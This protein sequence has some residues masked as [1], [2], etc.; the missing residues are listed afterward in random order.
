MSEILIFGGTTEGR[1]ISQVL[2]CNNIKCD[3]CVATEYGEQV[4]KESEN[5]NVH[6]GRMSLS[7]MQEFYRS[8]KTKIII[9]ATHPYATVVSENIRQSLIDDIK[10]IRFERETKTSDNDF[11]QYFDSVEDCIKELKNIKGNIFLTTGSKDLSKFCQ[12]QE[13]KNRII[14]RVLPGMESLKLCYDAGLEGK[15]IIAMQGPFSKAMNLLQIKEY[16]IST[17]VTKQS[18]KNGG[19]DEK[20]LACKKAGINCFVIKKE[21]ALNTKGIIQNFNDLFIELEK[22]LH[23][24]INHSC[25]LKINLCGIGM[26][27][28]DCLTIEVKKKI[29]ESKYIFGAQRMIDSVESGGKKYPYYLSKDIIPIL[30]DI[31]KNNYG[32]ITVSVLFSGDS[33][34]FSGSK[35]LSQELQKIQNVEI[36]S[37]PGISSLSYTAARFNI[38]YEDAKILSMHGINEEVWAPLL[39]E[40]LREGEKIFF[41]TSGKEDVMRIAEYLSE[42][43]KQGIKYVILLG[44][45]LSY[46]KERL[47]KIKSS[48][49]NKITEDGL[50]SGFLVKTEENKL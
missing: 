33:G 24:K 5:V 35:K 39:K 20:L 1:I 6:V 29:E 38:N 16:G 25:N 44:Y 11:C 41:I 46:K 42:Y 43:E 21:S 48:E 30:Q 26:G 13:I 34:F 14:A 40:Y 8:K 23:K 32:E 22:L 19:W 50:Y 45:E 37:Y 49:I 10:L 36:S 9:D 18:G 15:Q 31:Q 7:E 28:P 17:L 3:L 27:N 47:Y 4:L 12:N 2:S